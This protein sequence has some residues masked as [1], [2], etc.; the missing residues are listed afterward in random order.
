MENP[1]I[2]IKRLRVLSEHLDEMQHVNNVQ[3]LQWVQDVAKEHWLSIANPAWLDEFA[4]VVISH[5]IEYKKPTFLDEPII[6]K[7]HVGEPAG[8]RYDRFV[9]IFN[10]QTEQLL[11]QAYSVWCLLDKKTNRPIRVNSSIHE[12]FSQ[13]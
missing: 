10:E 6:I 13:H 11:V 3:Y 9:R 1:P 5:Q 8:A 7:T 2:F 4:W 12:A